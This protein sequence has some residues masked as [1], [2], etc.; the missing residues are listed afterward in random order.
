MIVF[1]VV[2]ALI[3]MV[4][5]LY[6]ASP[7]AK[8]ATGPFMRLAAF[9]IAALIALGA[10]G[11]YLA[12]GSPGLEGR[13][14]AEVERRLAEAEPETLTLPE[15]EE[16]LR[17]IARRNPD[18][19]QAQ[20]MLGRFLSRTDRHLEGVAMMERSLRIEADPRVMSDLG[21]SLVALNEGQVTPEAERA[22]LAAASADPDLPEPAFFLGAAA[23]DAGDRETAA[24]R[25]AVDAVAHDE[26]HAGDD[27]AAHQGV[28]A[29][30]IGERIAAGGEGR[31]PARAAVGADPGG[32]AAGHVEINKLTGTTG[33]ALP[34][35]LRLQ[36]DIGRAVGWSKRDRCR[37]A[38]D[39]IRCQCGRGEEVS[40]N[41]R[42]HD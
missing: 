41:N 5:A 19:A 35:E 39:D 30:A 8:G 10:L 12:G 22:F 34:G 25:W 16:R 27:G 40:Y 23:Y 3:G 37:Q 15:Q 26:L 6:I 17:S 33:H 1:A 2:I 38:D 13:P 21:Q 32:L 14:Y 28:D 29:P 11:A 42:F 18:D 36:L 31:T 20:A 24:E 4:G 9:G 7:L